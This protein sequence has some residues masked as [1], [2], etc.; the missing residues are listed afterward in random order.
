MDFRVLGPFE[1]RDADTVVSLGG[2]RQRAVLARL[3]IAVGAVVSTDTLIDDL[4]QGTPPATALASLHVYVSNLR[5]AIEPG[6]TPRTPPQLLI[7]RRPGYLLDTSDVDALRF[8]ALV[9]D[10][11]HRPS[12]QALP[13]LDEALG[14]W[15]GTPYGEFSGELWAVTEV[16]RLSE[17]RLVAIERRAEALLDL[18]RPQAVIN[19]LESQTTRHPLRERLWWLLA[20]AL[21][22]S[23][24]QA[25][26]LAT[27]R[28]VRKLIVQQLGL[29]PGPE[30]QSLEDD[31]LQ[32]AHSL[33]APANRVSP[34][35]TVL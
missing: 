5:R 32:Q 27:L 12:E 8:A 33:T 14:L 16:N 31:I 23:G 7:A 26:A 9:A 3:V 35:P 29:D 17:L 4:Y 25:D 13:R 28:R 30:L 21:Y 18:G 22:R 6:R 11:E 2:P 20:L 34:A 19:D 1:V 24:R 15:R 10:A